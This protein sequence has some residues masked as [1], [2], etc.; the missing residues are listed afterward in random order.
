MAA[1]TSRNSI[2]FGPLIW[3]AMA[4]A[5][6]G[7]GIFGYLQDVKDA[8]ARK[9]ALETTPPEI[10]PI[11]SFDLTANT[12]IANEA[13]ITAQVDFTQKG[14]IG[15]KGVPGAPYAYMLPLLPVETAPGAPKPDA[16]GVLLYKGNVAEFEAT[17]LDGLLDRITGMGSYGPIVELNGIAGTQG[18]YNIFV[19]DAFAR[20]NATI[21]P[22]AFT[23]EPFTQLRAQALVPVQPGA[24][25]ILAGGV[26]ILLGVGGMLSF[27]FGHGKPRRPNATAVAAAQTTG[28]HL[29]IGAYAPMLADG[30]VAKTLAPG[31][32]TPSASA[33]VAVSD[34]LGKGV[35]RPQSEDLDAFS[36]FEE[37]DIEEES[38]YAAVL[39]DD[40]FLEGFM[41]EKPHTVPNFE[42]AVQKTQFSTAWRSNDAYSDDPEIAPVNDRV[43]SRPKQTG[44]FASWH[45]GA[46]IR[47]DIK[48]SKRDNK[49]LDADPFMQR[50]SRLA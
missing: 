42:P 31:I 10:V 22:G 17:Y 47:D 5:V 46:S 39:E 49:K 2:R 19:V 26:A 16:L 40:D 12:G 8:N 27:A 41:A 7:I 14:Q 35:Y 6:I 28:N 48:L 18:A 1:E 32:L 15:I 44:I 43:Q 23:L 3:L 38:P 34:A 37:D 33:S 36:S 29:E 13:R 24:N 9:A 11:E 20:A 50:L 45:A 25:L 30:T 4:L 21:A